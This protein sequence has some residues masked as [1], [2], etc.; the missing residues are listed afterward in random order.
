MALVEPA[1]ERGCASTRRRAAGGGLDGRMVH[2]DDLA[3]DL[4]QQLAKG[5]RVRPAFLGL[6]GRR[7]AASARSAARKPRTRIG[8]AGQEQVD[9]FGGQ[10]DGALEASACARGAQRRRAA[11]RRRRCAHE[12][13]GGDVQDLV[14]RGAI[15]GMRQIASWSARFLQCAA[16]S[17][18]CA[19]TPNFPSSTAPTASTKSSRPR[20]ADGQPA[21]AITDLNNLFGAIKFY[22]EARGAGRQA[23]ASAPRCCCEGLGK[24]AGAL[25]A[26]RAAGAEHAGLPQPVRA[27]GARLDAERGARPRRCA[28]SSG[29]RSS[30]RA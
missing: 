11:R 27:A 14:A 7:S 2:A 30:A 6:A 16:C 28:S 22:K 9:A 15:L 13:V 18:T 21:L 25:V 8:R 20:P 23:A 5:L 1:L 26:H 29:C 10:Q 3:L 19:C 12:L 24:D 17:S 4:D